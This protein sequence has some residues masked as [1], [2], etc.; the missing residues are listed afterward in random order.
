MNKVVT[1]MQVE[2]NRN[3]IKKKGVMHMVKTVF[4]DTEALDGYIEASG[5]RI[6]YIADV[7]GIS[8]QALSM[9]RKGDISFRAAEV[10]V[11]CDLLKIPASEKPK[12]FCTQS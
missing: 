3:P 9:K 10:Y 1:L 7:L 2:K 12:I 6:G 4:V 5:L 11:L 8:N